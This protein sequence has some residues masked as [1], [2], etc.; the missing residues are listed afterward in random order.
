M[1]QRLSVLDSVKTLLVS[2]SGLVIQMPDMFPQVQNTP[3]GPQQLVSRLKS[4]PDTPQGLPTEYIHELITRFDGDG[5][6]MV[7]LCGKEV[8]KKIMQLKFMIDSWSC[9]CCY[10]K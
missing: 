1:D 3:L 9:Y 7:N 8:E 10:F 5:L 6:D 4:P 2:Y